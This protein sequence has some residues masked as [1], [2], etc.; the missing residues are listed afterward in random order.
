YRK[1]G[2]AQGE[3]DRRHSIGGT[4][5]AESTTRVSVRSAGSEHPA[6]PPS[7]GRPSA[8]PA[9]MRQVA[10]TKRD[11]GC[12]RIHV[13]L[14]RESWMVNYKK[15]ERLYRKEGLSLLRQARKR[16]RPCPASRCGCKA[17]LDTVMRWTLSMTVRPMAK[18]SS[19]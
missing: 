18:G 12:P 11:C 5:W 6:L 16:P 13:R 7:V 10:E 19:A 14:G 17:R 9:S 3:T 1:T 4:L 2:T 8:L 15:V